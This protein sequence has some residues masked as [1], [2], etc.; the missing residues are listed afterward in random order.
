MFTATELRLI[1]D[2]AREKEKELFAIKETLTRIN[3]AMHEV[4][5]A[6]GDSI[7]YTFSQEENPIYERVIQDLR[8]RQF[9]CTRESTRGSNVWR[10]E[11]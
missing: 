2:Y 1:T 5:V 9:Q 10:I 11:W 4:A 3:S 6:K 7:S 8:A